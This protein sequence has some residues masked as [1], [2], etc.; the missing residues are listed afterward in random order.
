MKLEAKHEVNNSEYYHRFSSYHYIGE[1]FK[2]LILHII[3]TFDG[4]KLARTH[5]EVGKSSVMLAIDLESATLM[6]RAMR[7][8]AITSVEKVSNS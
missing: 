6:L 1:D 2:T 5:I 8:N 4:K 7:E 3:R